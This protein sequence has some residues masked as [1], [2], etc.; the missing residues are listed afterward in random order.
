[1][2]AASESHTGVIRLLIERGA[3][4]NAASAAANPGR[5]MT[6]LLFS[7]RQGDL[8]SAR[9][10]VE[11][12][13]DMNAAMADATTPMLLAILNGH[14]ELAA[15]LLEKGA[16]PD[17]AD[18][19]GRTPLFAAIEL[20]NPMWAQ[21]PWPKGDNLD[22]LDLIQ[23]LLAHNAD[24]NVRLRRK[25][26]HRAFLDARWADLI[27]GVAFL[28]AAQTHDTTVMRLLLSYGADPNVIT[29]TNETALMLAA[30]VG[31]PLG[32]GYMR[33]EREIRDALE[34]CLALGMDVNAANADGVTSLMGAAHKGD[35][36]T[37]RL[38]VNHGAKLDAKDSEG[39]TALVWA[40]GVFGKSGLSIQPPRRQPHSEELLRELMNTPVAAND[41]QP[42]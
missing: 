5:K 7:A 1:M 12:G 39:R 21:V 37:I 23:R 42:E 30:G 35:N 11:A 24:P 17:L 29:T 8:Q 19:S 34:I 16:D 41:R 10:L 38:L 4:V 33:T 9:I 2:W 3:D 15:W 31:W 6:A 22:V 32:Q 13:A 27:G 26:S 18:N 28:R 14:Y 25:P 20:R 36:A 40:G